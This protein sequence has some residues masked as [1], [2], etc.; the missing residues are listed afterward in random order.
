MIVIEY[1]GREY[2]AWELEEG[3]YIPAL[4]VLIPK[5]AA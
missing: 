5:M 3:Y 2:D 1:A 4:N